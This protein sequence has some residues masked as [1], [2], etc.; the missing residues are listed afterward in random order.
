MKKIMAKEQL[1]M[2]CGLCEVYCIVSHSKTKDIIKAYNREQPR[3]TSRVNL[4]IHKPVSFAIQCR[5]CEDPPCVT[6]C[7]SG[8]MTKDEKSSLVVHDSERCIGCWTCIMVCPYGAIK[9]DS[10]GKAVSKCD[11]C[12][13]SNEPACVSNCPNNALIYKEVK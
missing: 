7:L 4:E 5:H 12:S 6:A 2:G 3:P 10:S 11:L 9:M 1:C 8:A 13:D